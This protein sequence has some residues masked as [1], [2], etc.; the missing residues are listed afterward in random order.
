MSREITVQVYQFEELSDKAKEKAREW[1]KDKVLNNDFQHETDSITESFEEKLEEYG[2]PT[3]NVNWSLSYS[4]GDGM[5]FYG[6]ID[7][8]EKVA[9]R[10]LDERKLKRFKTLVNAGLELILNI[11]RNSYG[12]HYSHYNTMYIDSDIYP[13]FIC[14]GNYKKIEKFCEEFIE[15][16]IK[17]VK[18]VSKELEAS[19]YKQIEYYYSNEYVD[20]EIIGNEY[21]FTEEG[22]I[23]KH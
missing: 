12:S 5:A 11:K 16:I 6:R 3:D 17:D 1:F 2:Y 13:S 10:L 22:V 4:Q 19:G 21:E 23:W 7:T 20:Q 15:L 8:L 9:E 14:N 18:S